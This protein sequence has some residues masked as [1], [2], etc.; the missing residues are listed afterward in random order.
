MKGRGSA[1]LLKQESPRILISLSIGASLFFPLSGCS[2]YTYVPQSYFLMPGSP[3]PFY[4]CYSS[5][6]CNDNY[7]VMQVSFSLSSLYS[8][9][10]VA[11]SALA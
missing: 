9:I 1:L 7:K 3:T 4:F 5:Y 10:E 6:S 8:G 11:K 2:I